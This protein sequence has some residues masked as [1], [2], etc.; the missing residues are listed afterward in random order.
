MTVSVAKTYVENNEKYEWL[1]GNARLVRYSGLLL[2]AH[3][4]FGFG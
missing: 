4:A 1:I 2:G 3:L